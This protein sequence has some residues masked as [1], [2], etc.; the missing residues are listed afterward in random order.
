MSDFSRL[1]QSFTLEAQAPRPVD[2]FA[3][4][5]PSPT[6]LHAEEVSFTQLRGPREITRVSHLRGQIALPASTV[7]DPGFAAREKK[8]T[9]R[10]SW[11][12]SCGMAS[13]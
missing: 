2:R 4:D 13:A 11:A 5:E 12:P 9:S 1:E 8:E 10:V 3:G 7:D 6:E